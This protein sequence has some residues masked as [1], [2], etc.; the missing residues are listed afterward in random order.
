MVMKYGRR[1]RSFFEGEDAKESHKSEH[2]GS[3]T[4]LAAAFALSCEFPFF[5]RI[6]KIKAVVKKNNF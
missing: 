5:A 4:F 2:F 3:K 6:L 1:F